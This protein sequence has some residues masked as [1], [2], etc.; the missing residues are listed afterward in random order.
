MSIKGK[1]NYL[2]IQF[3]NS[4]PLKK[5]V[6]EMFQVTGLSMGR[7]D[8]PMKSGDMKKVETMTACTAKNKRHIRSH[9]RTI[10]QEKN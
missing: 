6:S 1:K 4:K 3:K 7:P 9:W 10:A 8:L 5:F 2:Q